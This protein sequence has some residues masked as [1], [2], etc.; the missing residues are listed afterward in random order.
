MD[1]YYLFSC[2]CFS[3]Q[4]KKPLSILQ[5]FSLSLCAMFWLLS[6]IVF[7]WL[8]LC[9][10]FS[11]IIAYYSL[12]LGLGVPPIFSVIRMCVCVYI[13]VLFQQA[14][15]Y[16]KSANVPIG[17]YV[18]TGSSAVGT[19]QEACETFWKWSFIG[20]SELLLRLPGPT[21]LCS[22]SQLQLP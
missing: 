11:T 9:V 14:R 17:S 21:Y 13:N 20:L 10:N 4:Q 16:G 2:F 15:Y 18:C 7:V 5:S 8:L 3:D 19:T 1:Y 6:S 12:A 22:F